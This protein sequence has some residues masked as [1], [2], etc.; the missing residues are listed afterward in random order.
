MNKEQLAQLVGETVKETLKGLVGENGG[1]AVNP[2]AAPAITTTTLKREPQHKLGAFAAL[3]FQARK[4]GV[5]NPNAWMA[6]KAKEVYGDNAEITKS[7][8]SG[9]ANAGSEFVPTVVS[10]DVIEA[11]TDRTVMRRNGSKIITNHTGS[12]TIPKLTSTVQGTWV[13]EGP[14]STNRAT[15]PG[16]DNVSL[17]WN[18]MKVTVP[19]S[20]ELLMFSG[21]NIEAAITDNVLRGAAATEDAAFLRK[22]GSA[23]TPTG[24]L[25][26][27][28]VGQKADTTG[29]T[30]DNIETDL[31]KLI[32]LL[33]GKNMMLSPDSSVFIMHSRSAAALRRLR[34]ANGNLIFPEI[35]DNRLDRFKLE[36]TNSIP[37]NIDV[38][39]ADTTGSEVYFV[40]MPDIII[41][42]ASIQSLEVLENVT[43]TDSSGNLQTTVD[44]D[45]AVVSL[46]LRTDIAMQYDEAAAVIEKVKWGV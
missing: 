14:A 9:T 6:E 25:N 24:V 46:T 35:K 34:D 3:K 33:E 13:G 41:A 40:N 28:A 45:E 17:T 12:M 39:G 27:M 42:D 38:G 26:Q 10:D 11:L 43:Y 19:I 37:T 8:L 21:P 2:L 30:A 1:N 18:K 22:T 31:T 7:L 32:Q 23:T 15:K 44:T 16:T 20:K 5:N 36:I 29:A 4:A